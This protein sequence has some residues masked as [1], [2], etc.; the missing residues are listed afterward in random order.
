M[1]SP[2]AMS[3][4]MWSPPSGKTP[5]YQTAPSRKSATSVVPPPRSMTRTPSSFS[6]SSMIASAEASASSTTSWTWSPARLTLRMTLRTDVV[7]PV[8][9]CTSTSSRT[10]DMPR[11]SLTPSW[12]STT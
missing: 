9:R 1:R 10:P 11:G 2:T 12:S 8:T 4:E 6:S 7:A 5:V 3:F